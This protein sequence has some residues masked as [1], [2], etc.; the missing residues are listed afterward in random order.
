V[1]VLTQILS[2]TFPNYTNFTNLTSCPKCGMLA[3]H[4]KNFEIKVVPAAAYCA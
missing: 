1:A 3:F 2:D 4:E